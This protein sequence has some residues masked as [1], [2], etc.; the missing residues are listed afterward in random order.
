MISLLLVLIGIGL[1]YAGGE[2][3]VKGAKQ[4]ALALGL[5]PLVVGL[6]V[7]AFGTSSPEL[8]ATLLAA[9]RGAPDVAI[10]NI[11]GSNIA[12]IGLIL[13]LSALLRPL[14]AHVKVLWRELPVMIGASL[15]L[16]LLAW[17]GRFGRVDGLLMLACFSLYLWMLLRKKEEA[18]VAIGVGEDGKPSSRGLQV[19]LI[20][21]GIGLLVLGAELLVRGAVDLARSIG[22][23]EQIIGLTLVAVGTSLPELAAS[24]VAAAHDDGD[25]VLGNVIGS[26][27]FNVLFVLA[28]TTLV[29]P[30]AVDPARFQ[31]DM[32]VALLFSAVVVPLLYFRQ[33]HHLGKVEGV[34][35]LLAYIGYV[36]T[37][38]L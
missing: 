24:L 34:V 5:S 33:K 23:S 38:F 22:L 2:A 8:A 35:L 16:I 27:V 25:I 10:G 3:L 7:V 11:L 17:N 29:H 14:V 6:T 4:L 36:V 19:L 31:R 13:A 26:N 12:N 18:P 30:M 9:L 15:L 37:L 32:V 21:G 1:L 28:I 20:A